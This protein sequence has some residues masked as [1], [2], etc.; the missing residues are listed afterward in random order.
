MA[1]NIDDFWK[2]LEEIQGTS[3]DLNDSVKAIAKN[4]QTVAERLFSN[5]ID[6]SAYKSAD[7]QRMRSF[8][9][10]GLV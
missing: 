1:N 7:Y 5:I 3:T 6:Q 8:I 2:I 9:N 10:N 4:E